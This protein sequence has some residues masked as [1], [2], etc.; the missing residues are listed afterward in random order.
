LHPAL[1]EL[2]EARR[3]LEALTALLDGTPAGGHVVIRCAPA[4]ESRTRGPFNQHVRDLRAR[5]SLREVEI[6]PDPVLARGAWVIDPGE[7]P[8]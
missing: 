8:G 5:F 4:D 1:R 3:A 2:I 6:R 7:E